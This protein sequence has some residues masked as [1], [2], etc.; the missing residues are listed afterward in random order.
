MVLELSPKSRADND[1][2]KLVEEG[3]AFTAN[4]PLVQAAPVTPEGCALRTLIDVAYA[5]SK[6]ASFNDL[7]LERS[8][9]W[10]LAG[11]CLLIAFTTMI[12]LLQKNVLP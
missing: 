6:P 4:G 2:E 10:R 3:V 5:E 11:I 7:L 1:V 12:F 9:C 8:F